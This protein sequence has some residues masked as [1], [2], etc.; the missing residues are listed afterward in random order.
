MPAATNQNGFFLIVYNTMYARFECTLLVQSTA[1]VV[2]SLGSASAASI[3]TTLRSLTHTNI[4]AR[5][6]RYTRSRIN[7]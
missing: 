1:L 6:K 3:T 5:L 2:F 7:V 4:H